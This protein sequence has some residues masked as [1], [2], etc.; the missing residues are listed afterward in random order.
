M[1]TLKKLLALTLALAMVLSVSV[2]AGYLED[3]YQDAANI[4]DGAKEA[5]EVLTALNIMKGVNAEGT[6]A[7]NEGID[8]ASVAK[9]IYVILNY[10]KDDGAKNYTNGNLYTDVPTGHWAE[11]YINYCTVT[12]LVAGR[13]DGNFGPADKISAAEVAK[14]L[15]TAIGY[16]ADARGY[17]GAGWR[18]H[19]MADAATV[20]LFKGVDANINETFL[21]RQWV[22]VMFYNAL[23]DA[24]TYGNMFAIANNGLLL[25]SDG[26]GQTDIITFGEKYKMGVKVFDGLAVATSSA[27]IDNAKYTD[28]GVTFWE[29]GKSSKPVT[30]TG[31]GL[32]S[33]D[34]GQMYHVVGIGT[35]ALGVG[36]LT[37][38]Y[39]TTR[40]DMDTRIG[41]DTSGNNA[42]NKYSF[43]VNGTYMP[44]EGKSVNVLQTGF[45]EADSIDYK[46]MS[47]AQ[48]RTWVDE[49]AFTADDV[50]IID[51]DNDR[52]IDY[53]IVVNYSYAEMSGKATSNKYGT[54]IYA[55]DLKDEAAIKFNN[56]ARMYIDD[57]IIT[58][59]ELANGDT[60]KYTWNV[61]EGMYAME[62]LPTEE[63]AELESRNIRTNTYV[64]D[65][66]T[67]NYADRGATAGKTLIE[68][69]KI[70][71]E[72]NYV[73]DGVLLVNVTEPDK[74]A[75]SI[76]AVNEMLVL[77]TDVNDE[78][79]HN[80]IREENAI[81][82]M[83]IDGETHIGVYV[84]GKGLNFDELKTRKLDDQTV[85]EQRLYILYKSG[86]NVYVKD[87]PANPDTASIFGVKTSVVDDYNE[88]TD[89]KL[90]ATGSTA[91]I[92][93][94]KIAANDYFFAYTKDGALKYAVI[95][96][97]KFDKGT[98]DTAYAQALL[99]G[100]G[101]KTQ[102]VAGYIFAD[103]KSATADGYFF[104]KEIGA[105]TK[106]GVELSVLFNDGKEGTIY[107]KNQDYLVGYLYSY[108]Y[109][110]VSEEYE[111]HPVYD[112][113]NVIDAF[114]KLFDENHNLVDDAKL[115]DIEDIE[116][117]DVYFADGS[118]LNIKDRVVALTTVTL[119]RGWTEDKDFDE[120]KEWTKATAVEY[121]FL[122]SA[123]DNADLFE[124]HVDDKTYTQWTYFDDVDAGVFYVIRILDMDKAQ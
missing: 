2:F 6:F 20:G 10:G 95:E 8:R 56:N 60:V 48:F 99:V 49:A 116:G 82:Y 79:S 29:D 106:N 31:T 77:I 62:V 110:V 89:V 45:V 15:L 34:L 74:R 83:T 53:V 98:A 66:A 88:L 22:A 24:L 109:T 73:Y 84:D 117:N 67:L 78:Y 102:M 61:D 104:V 71:N 28:D 58:D 93:N 32:T 4:N 70:G 41:Y 44:L 36:S 5:V 52:T 50:K 19:V 100:S 9:M 87:I 121:E 63:N 76:D 105:E 65:G 90:D 40:M 101:R 107:V 80:T 64:L 57:C 3:K 25:K 115:S 86:K 54:Y 72:M 46:E 51:I 81:E 35:K 112:V 14:M 55:D 38:T 111:I 23:K 21:N 37:D 91:K 124:D 7:P 42:K 17:V 103:I 94:Y 30:M 13:G 85:A 120:F 43:N 27:R 69:T 75:N 18:E 68:G 113:E 92:D 122:K 11:G 118:K 97:G 39:E 114:G 16:N 26:V 1:S 47:E 33:M 119:D 123:A 108:T 12:N 96:D 59:D